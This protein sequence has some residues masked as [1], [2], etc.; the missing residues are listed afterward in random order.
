MI[1]CCAKHSSFSFVDINQVANEKQSHLQEVKNGQTNLDK[2]SNDKNAE[3]KIK[4]SAKQKRHE[5]SISRA[6]KVGASQNAVLTNKIQVLEEGLQRLRGI[7]G[8]LI[9]QGNFSGDLKQLVETRDLA[10]N[11]EP[12]KR[13]P[14]SVRGGASAKLPRELSTKA[15][16]KRP[17]TQPVI[18][19]Q[20]IPENPPDFSRFQ[21]ENE[22][23]GGK[24]APAPKKGNMLEKLKEARRH[25]KTQEQPS[26]NKVVK[27]ESNRDTK[28]NEFERVVRNTDIPDGP[29]ISVGDDVSKVEEIVQEDNEMA[30]MIEQE[31]E[32]VLS[33]PSD[34][35]AAVYAVRLGLEQMQAWRE[36]L[37]RA[38]EDF[39]K[40]I[41][42]CR[43]SITKIQGDLRSFRTAANAQ[44]CK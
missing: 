35:E 14:R 21:T 7:V 18:G 40:E 3:K 1:I 27:V 8:D 5:A 2:F 39:R 29:N 4:N 37:L 22:Q 32:A 16:A 36:Q 12:S 11:V 31:I 43:G 6:S 23:D 15:M 26:E 42:T 19:K 24:K 17:F 30:K 41:G 34:P 28:D 25:T 10:T 9:S 33:D 38:Q 44:V 13:N 20:E